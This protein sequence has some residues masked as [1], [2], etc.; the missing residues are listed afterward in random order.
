MI[1]NRRDFVLAGLAG[2]AGAVLPG[3]AKAFHS[4]DLIRY[5]D[6]QT[7]LEMALWRPVGPQDRDATAY[8]FVAPWCPRCSELILSAEA[9]ELPVNLRLVPA[10][11]RSSSDRQKIWD[12]IIHEGEEAVGAFHDRRPTTLTPADPESLQALMNVA[13]MTHQSTSIWNKSI[14]GKELNA[15]PAVVIFKENQ[16]SETGTMPE[17]AMG[18]SP[19]IIPEYKRLA[20]PII[21]SGG[22][23]PKDYFLDPPRLVDYR[24][25]G[26]S[27]GPDRGQTR[28]LPHRNALLAQCFGGGKELSMMVGTQLV[29]GEEWMVTK[30]SDGKLLFLDPDQYSEIS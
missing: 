23:F 5:G 21:S 8:A 22:P 9:G 30:T 16:D 15:T 20:R 18:F 28:I 25:R 10:Y 11:A 24:G 3:H 27:T 13:D 17:I 26:V 2:L 19:Q 7:G 6:L 29:F 1:L 4:C 12:L 14:Y